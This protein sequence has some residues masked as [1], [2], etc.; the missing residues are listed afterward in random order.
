MFFPFIESPLN[1]FIIDIKRK[2]SIALNDITLVET[3]FGEFIYTQES[4]KHVIRLQIFEEYYDQICKVNI[5]NITITNC[6]PVSI[7]PSPPTENT[8][9][10]T[11]L[12]A[13]SISVLIFVACVVVLRVYVFRE[14]PSTLRRRRRRRYNT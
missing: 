7:P 13:I 5:P 10:I 1:A 8:I 14:K 2:M 4:N 11:L 9:N 12:I 6:T 3:I